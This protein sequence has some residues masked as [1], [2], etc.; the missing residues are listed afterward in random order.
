MINQ[1]QRKKRQYTS[2]WHMQET[3]TYY[4]YM[5]LHGDWFKH[6]RLPEVFYA[7]TLWNCHE[8]SELKEKWQTHLCWGRQTIEAV[9]TSERGK[10]VS[11]HLQATPAHLSGCSSLPCCWFDVLYVVS[12]SDEHSIKVCNK[13]NQIGIRESKQQKIQIY[14]ESSQYVMILFS[15]THN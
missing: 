9:V 11:G 1:L 15:I 13:M 2:C 8:R 10:K 12:V 3:Y 5:W 6:V 7:S 14:R 4:M